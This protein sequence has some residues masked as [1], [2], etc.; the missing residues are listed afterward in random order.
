MNKRVRYCDECRCD[1]EVV[2]KERNSTYTFRN[3]PFDIIEEYAQCTVCGNDVTDEELDNKTLKRISQLYEIKHSY[4]PEML[5]EIR[6][7]FDLPQSLFAKLLNMGIATIKRYELGTSSPDS[8]QI[9]IY[10]LL[11]NNP[12]A[13]KQ[14]FEQ[15]QA[16]FE[17]DELRT[18]REKLKPFL[19]DD[20]DLEDTTQK[21]LEMTYKQHEHT[22]ETGYSDFKAQKLFQMILYFSRERVLKTKLMKLL[23]YSD[24]LQFKRK[25]KPISG[26]PYWHLPYG[27]VPK[28]HD[29]LLGSMEGMDLISIRE[30]ETPEGYTMI[31]IK[32]KERYNSN[33]FD[34]EEWETI[35]YVDEYFKRFGSRAIS[36]FA[37]K[38]AAWKATK[39]EEIISY[40]YADLLQLN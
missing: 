13:I 20:D 23:W 29:L 37:H 10:K 38:E 11:K 34:E 33:I 21:L 35:R 30:D 2:I 32:A 12:K 16:R 36:D 18:V 25:R 39:D 6:K 5:R 28:K 15:N 22:I 26:T 9:G 8:T 17:P 7:T 24:F 40:Q 14:F 27:P 3:E 4:T 31:E 19:T 1:R